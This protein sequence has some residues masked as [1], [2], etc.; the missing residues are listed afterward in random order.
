MPQSPATKRRIEGDPMRRKRAKSQSKSSPTHSAFHSEESKKLDGNAKTP[1]RLDTSMEK[2]TTESTAQNGSKSKDDKQDEKMFDKDGEED[3]P[4]AFDEEMLK[5]LY[6]IIQG[7]LVDILSVIEKVRHFGC[8]LW[9]GSTIF[10]HQARTTV[11][12]I[13]HG[14]PD[15][16]AFLVHLS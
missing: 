14:T 4:S 12:A 15:S 13:L 9:S 7:L 6:E 10:K 5:M 3:G 8:V 2:E 16:L 1:E 11:S